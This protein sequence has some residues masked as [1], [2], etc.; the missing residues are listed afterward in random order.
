MRD[1]RHAATDDPWSFTTGSRL[2]GL[3]CNSDQWALLTPI[4]VDVVTGK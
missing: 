4:N 3:A 2:S 1:G